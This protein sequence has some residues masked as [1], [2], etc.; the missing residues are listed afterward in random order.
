MK[1]EK[2]EKK[3]ADGTVAVMKP[4]D[5]CCY[6]VEILKDGERI[7][8]G[9]WCPN[10]KRLVVDGEIIGHYNTKKSVLKEIYPREVTYTVY[11]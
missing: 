10:S 7:A 3:L 6:L 8:D 1:P 4:Y 5:E 2:L 9:M 11:F